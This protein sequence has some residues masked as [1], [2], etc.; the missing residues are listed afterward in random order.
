MVTIKGYVAR[1]CWPLPPGRAPIRDAISRV[2]SRPDPYSRQP[3]GRGYCERKMTSK[4]INPRATR[5]EWSF[6]YG[7]CFTVAPL[8]FLKK[9]RPDIGSLPSSRCRR[10]H[11]YN[12][13][14]RK[15]ISILQLHSDKWWPSI[16]AFFIATFGF[17]RHK[18]SSA[19]P[20]PREFSR[21]RGNPLWRKMFPGKA[22]IEN[23]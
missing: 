22:I 11:W 7:R 19:F 17:S 2:P 3:T 9:L 10:R 21:N 6:S 8:K 1:K 16:S 20:W 5:K 15:Y 12:T 13:W 4:S 23:V 18:N 14:K